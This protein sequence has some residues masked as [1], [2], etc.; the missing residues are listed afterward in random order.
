MVH[1]H[2]GE[3]R[4]RQLMQQRQPLRQ[5]PRHAETCYLAEQRVAVAIHDQTGQPVTIRV[6]Q[7]VGVSRGIELENIPPQRDRATD[8]DREIG[9]AQQ[10]IRAVRNDAQHHLGAWVEDTDTERLAALVINRHQVAGPRIGGNV[11]HQTRK[12]RGLKSEVFEL[13]PG[14]GALRW[15]NRRG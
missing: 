15:R 14:P 9:L 4:S 6:N 8:G 5:T 10:S 7:T 2:A 3:L 12:N 1:V 13:R 11:A